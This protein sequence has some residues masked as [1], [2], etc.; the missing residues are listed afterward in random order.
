M[1]SAHKYAMEMEVVLDMKRGQA[2]GGVG[3]TEIRK[4]GGVVVGHI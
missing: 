2:G 1:L 3:G 4:Y